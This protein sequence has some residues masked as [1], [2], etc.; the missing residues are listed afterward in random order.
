MFNKAVSNCRVVVV[1]KRG[2]RVPRLFSV[3]RRKVERASSTKETSLGKKRG[4]SRLRP[5]RERAKGSG[6]EV[7]HKATAKKQQAETE[8]G[9]AN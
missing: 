3:E 4:R 1:L 8:E 7:V 9:R 5:G 6:D 2:A